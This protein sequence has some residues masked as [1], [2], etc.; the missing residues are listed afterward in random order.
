[1][2]YDIYMKI[3]GFILYFCVFCVVLAFLILI[4]F[5]FIKR[6]MLS[7]SGITCLADFIDS[8]NGSF[9]NLLLIPLSVIFIITMSEYN[10]TTAN[11]YIRNKKRTVIISKMSLKMLIFSITVSS[12]IS[13]ISIL[14]AALLTE[15]VMNWN[16]YGSYFYISRGVILNISFTAV[17][18]LSIIKLLFPILF[19]R[20]LPVCLIKS[21]KKYI[22]FF[23]LYC[24]QDQIF[25]EL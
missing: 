23:L 3:K 10:C 20:L 19:L 7:F 25:L 13:V 4:Y 18:L 6:S 2:F 15:H 22:L 24:Y 1:M 21:Q 11:Y 14:I 12:L 8:L 5:S 17:F 16:E 9:F